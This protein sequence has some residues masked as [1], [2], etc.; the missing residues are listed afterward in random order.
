MI[1]GVIGCLRGEEIKEVKVQHVKEEGSV[2][3]V[4]SPFTKNNTARQ[5]TIDAVFSKIVKKYQELRPKNYSGDRF[6]L[7]YQKLK[8]TKQPIGKNKIAGVPK[9][10]ATWLNLPNPS[11]YT[12]HALR[13]TSATVLSNTGGTMM[14]VKHLGGWQSDKIAQGYIDN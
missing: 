8:C 13:R 7:N 5:F 12:G 4:D 2:I 6:F 10:I 3:I 9:E 11:L 1:F 14:D